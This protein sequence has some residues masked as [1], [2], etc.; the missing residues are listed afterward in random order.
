M[1]KILFSCMLITAFTT[2]QIQAQCTRAEIIN[3][4]NTIYLGTTVSTA[5]LAW[6]G[7]YTTCLPGTISTLAQNNTLARINYFRKLV[8]VPEVT[9]DATM[10]TKCQVTA[11]MM[12][13]NGTAIHNPPTNWH[14][15]TE[16]GAATAAISLM[17]WRAHS[18]DAIKLYID[19]TGVD[20]VGDR[21]NILYS[22]ATFFAHGS[23]TLSDVL[24]TTDRS[25]LNPIITNDICYPSAGFFPA[26]LVP[27]SWS[28]SHHNAD[29]RSADV[30]M[31]G[32]NGSIAVTI[33]Q[34]WDGYGD[35]TIAW[36]PA[37]I[38]KT[39]IY[40]VKYTVNISNVYYNSSWHNITYDVILC[41]PSHP[42]QCPAGL[43]WSDSECQCSI[44]TGIEESDPDDI[45]IS[46]VNPFTDNLEIRINGKNSDQEYQISVI[47]INGVL[48]ATER[49]RSTININ[50]VSWSNGVYFI[51]AADQKG[52]KDVLRAIKQ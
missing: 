3:D 37:G 29:F 7:N 14:C 41:Q 27:A 39:S 13:A 22:R 44:P 20:F 51:I 31:T 6:T 26:P 10:N 40:D 50:T 47:D 9:F 30:T 21:R 36:I 25:I 2:V 11:L 42:P 38:N 32:P 5:Q 46:I 17:A 8:G 18:A 52:N 15:Y 19:D 12:G 34:I 4:Y 48:K 16:E 1:M 23:T 43:E 24:Y 49:V 33:G 28:F 35:N 45:N